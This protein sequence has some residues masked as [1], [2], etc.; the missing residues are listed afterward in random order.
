MKILIVDDE[1][2]ARERLQRLTAAI[3][4]HYETEQAEHGLDAV[5]KMSSSPADIILMDIRMPVMDGLEAAHHLSHL[6]PGPV[7]IFTTA[8]EDHALQAFEAHAIDYLLKPVKKDRLELALRRA[9]LLKEA[10]INQ[11][12]RKQE[13]K[14]NR[15]YLSATFKGELK[16]VAVKDIRYFKAEQ[17]YVV[18]GWPGGQL[19]LDE[20]LQSLE[21]EFGDQFVRIHRNALVARKHIDSIVKDDQGQPEILLNGV[22]ARLAVSRRN[23]SYIR[24]NLKRPPPE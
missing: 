23:I 7:I 20:S 21:E 5:N 1:P 12:R 8:Y 6:D 10:T 15:T 11:L 2:L 3:D 18:A 24:R 4:E 22:D 9:S 14:K 13:P 19:L 16:L 17:K